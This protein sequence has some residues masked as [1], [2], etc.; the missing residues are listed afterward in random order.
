MS[1][2]DLHPERLLEQELRGELDEGDRPHLCEHLEQCAVCRFELGA[3]ADFRDERE[4]LPGDE[5][6]IE[7]VL[8][9][10]ILTPTEVHRGVPRRS[11]KWVMRGLIAVAMTGLVV[12]AGATVGK[13]WLPPTQMKE[14]P[15]PVTPPPPSARPAA[16]PIVPHR[17]ASP[18]ATSATSTPS[19]A[20]PETALTAAQLFERANLQRRSGNAS[21]AAR[22]YNTLQRQ[23]PSSREAS[24]SR[25]ALARLML[26]RQGNPAGALQLFNAYLAGGGM[27]QQEAMLG[28]AI[29]LQQLGRT[30][31]ERAAWQQIVTSFPGSVHAE[32]AKKRLEQLQ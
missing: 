16:A 2:L 18:S 5:D 29:A 31:E 10:S 15:T 32:R 21:E 4:P 20:A 6:L 11:R 17:T 23:Y 1:S 28:R 7:R 12:A 27:L 24:A 25:L 3:A 22:L 9:T 26:D 8:A 30:A 19:Q 14:A 13:S